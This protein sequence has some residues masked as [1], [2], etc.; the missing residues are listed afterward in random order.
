VKF[1]KRAIDFACSLLALIITAPFFAAAALA[2]R[3]STHLPAIFRQQR[4]GLAG[5]PFTVYK[6]RTMTDQRDSS[7]RLL[8]DAERLSPIGKLLR[9]TSLDELPQLINVLRGEMS[10]V[11]PRPLHLEYLPR[12]NAFERRRHEVRPGITGWAQI[13]GRN[14]IS[15]QERFELDVWYVDHWSLLLDFRILAGTIGKV[16]RREGINREN[17]V[18]MPEFL[19]TE[20]ESSQ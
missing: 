5:K 13:H 20:R 18:A 7:G 19:G 2:V 4:A 12:Y 15:W 14:T 6:F 8:A 16:L 3:G 1:L 17:Q 9:K 11:G 10:L